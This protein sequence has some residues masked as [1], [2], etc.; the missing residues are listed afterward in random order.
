VRIGECG[1]LIEL[2]TGEIGEAHGPFVEVSFGDGFEDDARDFSMTRIMGDALV[3]VFDGFRF[4]FENL[5]ETAAHVEQNT[6]DVE[7]LVFLPGSDN[8]GFQLFRLEGMAR[9]ARIDAMN[10]GHG[11]DLLGPC[12]VAYSSVARMRNA[13]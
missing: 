3:K 7:M 4:A 1:D 8:E 10:Q 9:G 12:V 5:E 11:A 13:G 2:V 6:G